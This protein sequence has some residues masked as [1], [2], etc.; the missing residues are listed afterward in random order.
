MAGVV[1]QE[2]CDGGAA[3]IFPWTWN[4]WELFWRGIW[5]A[6][7][8]LGLGLGRMAPWVFEACLGMRK[9]QRVTE[10]EAA[11]IKRSCR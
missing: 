6:S 11:E 2:G 5:N 7:E 10:A 8:V 3:V 1:P 9:G 4:P